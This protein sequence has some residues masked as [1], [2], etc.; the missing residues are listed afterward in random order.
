MV[1]SIDKAFDLGDQF[2]G[3]VT[4][5]LGGKW[6]VFAVQDPLLLLLVQ[7]GQALIIVS[8][9]L[10]LHNVNDLLHGAKFVAPAL[11][12]SPDLVWQDLDKEL[13]E[14]FGRQVEGIFALV[15]QPLT[16]V[17]FQIA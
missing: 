17:H 2:R 13:A 8:G 3:A 1:Y 16:Y 5:Q 7:A 4:R 12:F 10:I 9:D 14:M 6:L 15:L 11:H